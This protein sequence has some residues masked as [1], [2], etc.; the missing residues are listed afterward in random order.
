[1]LNL[2]LITIIICIY[3]YIYI[4]INN[5][6][7]KKQSE[8]NNIKKYNELMI[9]ENYYK[10]LDIINN[11]DKK[12]VEYEKNLSKYIYPIGTIIYYTDTNLI[13][14]PEH[15]CPCDGRILETKSYPELYNIIGILFNKTS[16][17]SSF[18]NIPDLRNLFIKCDVNNIGVIE[19]QNIANHTHDFLSSNHLEYCLIKTSSANLLSRYSS[20]GHIIVSPDITGTTETR[21]KNVAV[22][23]LIKIK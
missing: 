14:I 22:N 18:F 12:L 2:I 19:E 21:P 11:I 6:I 7:I 8:F 15:F 5:I 23:A 9:T 20:I 16:D 10:Q 3:I 4:Q 1:M 13:N 17:S